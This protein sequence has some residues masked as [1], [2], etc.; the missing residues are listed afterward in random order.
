MDVLME[1]LRKIA[2]DK[3]MFVVP[4]KKKDVQKNT[5]FNDKYTTKVILNVM[6]H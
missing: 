1:D 4:S 2:H 6:V 5:I 3:D